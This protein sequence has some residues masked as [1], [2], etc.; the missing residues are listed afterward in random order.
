MSYITQAHLEARYGADEIL[1]LADRDG[2]SIPDTD[3]LN[4]AIGDAGEV[5]DSHL[6]GRFTLPLDPVPGVI[7]RL[8]CSIARYHL[9]DEAPTRHVSDEYRAA[10]SALEKIAS[11]ELRLA[12]PDGGPD[13]TEGERQF[14]DIGEY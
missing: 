5:I 7:L 11:G 13:Y 8:A 6:A 4:A 9:Y 10:V 14:N 3:V 2:D 12:R 1:R